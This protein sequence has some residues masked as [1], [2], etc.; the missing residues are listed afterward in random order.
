MFT[1]QIHISCP[2]TFLASTEKMASAETPH[3]ELFDEEK[4]IMING[5]KIEELFSEGCTIS[6]DTL[7][8][9]HQMIPDV[10]DKCINSHYGKKGIV[11]Y[12]AGVMEVVQMR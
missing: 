2:Q 11:L 5:I 10:V 3:Y 9:I 1:L 8:V 6:S 4:N 12:T 7:D